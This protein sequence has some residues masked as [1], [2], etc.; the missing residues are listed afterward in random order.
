LCGSR[1]TPA[2]TLHETKT[3]FLCRGYRPATRVINRKC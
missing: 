1:W 2:D 3:Q